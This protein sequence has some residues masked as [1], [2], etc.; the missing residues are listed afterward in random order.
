MTGGVG[1][2]FFRFPG[3]FDRPPAG[4]HQGI[5]R[6]QQSHLAADP[7]STFSNPIENKWD[8]F[9]TEEKNDERRNERVRTGIIRPRGVNHPTGE[10]RRDATQ[11]VHGRTA[12]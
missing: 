4:N 8:C 9:S 5:K 1:R 7:N 3:K 6:F 12:S 2:R 10:R 11:G